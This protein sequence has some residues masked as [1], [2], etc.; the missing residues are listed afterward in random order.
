LNSNHITGAEPQ[1]RYAMRS[2]NFSQDSLA[3]QW[4]YVNRNLK[5][6][7]IWQDLEVRV[8]R[9]VKRIIQRS[10]EEDFLRRIGARRYERSVNRED[11]RCG[12]Y[13]RSFSTIYGRVDGLK[14]PV[15]RNKRVKF[16]FFDKYQRR[17]E[18]F[19][20]AILIAMLL[21]LTTRKQRM[22]FQEFLKD[23]VSHQTA[24]RILRD[25]R[26]EV[27][28]YR[29][30]PILDIYKYLILDGFW[31]HLKELGIRR[32]VVLMALGIRYDGQRELL[33]FKL[34]KGETE[35]ECASFLNDLFNRGLE[36]RYLRC[37]ISDGS[38]GFIA[39]C[40]MVYPYVKRQRCITHKLRNIMQNLRY[41]KRHKKRLLSQAS[42]IY[43]ARSKREATKRFERFK[44]RWQRLEPKAVR[45]FEK[46]FYDSLTYY[47]FPEKDQTYIKSTN[48]LERYQRETRKVARRVGYFQ[49]EE[50][51]D[52]FIYSV[53]KTVKLSR[54]QLDNS[55]EYD[56]P[57]FIF[58]LI[59]E[60]IKYKSAKDS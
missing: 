34:A 49:T 23:S 42:S 41:K 25:I 21:G 26:Q 19:N 1:R 35:N 12:Y 57:D 27:I 17:H 6:L 47:D 55:Q 24:S 59:K 18:E 11:Y 29:Q 43:K 31:I 37:I 48:H 45:C 8:K 4:Q 32:R 38:D 14:I 60:P 44:Y 39:A 20:K 52:L 58:M 54:V 13:E 50:S 10:V 36:G 28:S 15:A 51:L 16:R 5:D 40:N 53:V 33:A 9:T 7:G 2:I 46:D 30:K 3:L 22:F 56:M